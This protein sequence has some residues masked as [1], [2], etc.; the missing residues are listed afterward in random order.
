MD[1]CWRLSL[2]FCLTGMW[3]CW[4]SWSMST[5]TDR[6]T[7]WCKSPAQPFSLLPSPET[8]FTQVWDDFDLNQDALNHQNHSSRLSLLAIT[9]MDTNTLQHR[10][11]HTTHNTQG[12]LIPS[13]W[14]GLWWSGVFSRFPHLV[15]F[16]DWFNR[17][18]QCSMVM[19][20][21]GLSILEE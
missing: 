16:Q 10:H 13:A 6:H 19:V 18:S 12:H 11:V 4:D 14:H 15:G 7:S 20:L 5:H 3:P 1:N 2:P 21:H 17:E 8:S 9:D